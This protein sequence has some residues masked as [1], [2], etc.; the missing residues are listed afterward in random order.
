MINQ[1]TPSELCPL[2]AIMDSIRKSYVDG[3]RYEI[4]EVKAEQAGREALARRPE[5]VVTRMPQQSSL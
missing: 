2:N 1:Y 5:R 4:A 3:Y